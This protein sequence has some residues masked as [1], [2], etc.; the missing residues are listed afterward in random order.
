MLILIEWLYECKNYDQIELFDEYLVN[1]CIEIRVLELYEIYSFNIIIVMFEYDFLRVGKFCIYLGLKGQ[2]YES[3]LLF[4]D[5]VLMK[6]CLE[7]QG[8]FVFYYWK[9]EFLVD[10]YFFVQQFGFLVVV[11]LIDGLGFVD[12]KVL[13]NEKDMM[14]YL[15]KGFDGNVEVEMFVDGDMYYIDG[16]MIDGY[17]ILNWF[18][19]YINGCL[20]F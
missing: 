10:L 13:K 2:F 16:F 4:W 9:I 15:F 3:V 18:F 14:K 19:W 5:K 8:I 12:I 11:K 20:V 1:G 6:Q 17:I 7:E